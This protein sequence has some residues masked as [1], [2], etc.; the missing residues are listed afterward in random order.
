[1][2]LIKH[3]S[4]FRTQH[5]TL[6]PPAILHVTPKMVSTSRD[7]AIYSVHENQKV[8][9]TLKLHII[10]QIKQLRSLLFAVLARAR[11]L[12]CHLISTF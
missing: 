8:S 6:T 1:M 3:T 4:N 12:L 7:H 9:C 10:V 2:Y 11:V 5:S